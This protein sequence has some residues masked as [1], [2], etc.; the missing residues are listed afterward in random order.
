MHKR[1]DDTVRHTRPPR[2]TGATRTI[3][4]ALLLFWKD[5]GS[6]SEVRACLPVLEVV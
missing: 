2:A 1:C 5:M 4:L 6:V 3:D